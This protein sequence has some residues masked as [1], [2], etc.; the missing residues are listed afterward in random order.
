MSLKTYTIDNLQQALS[1]V[2]DYTGKLEITTDMRNIIHD[3]IDLGE[4]LAILGAE[5][6]LEKYR[7]AVTAEDFLSIINQ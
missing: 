1:E 7:N 4:I 2:L 5:V 6:D 3:S